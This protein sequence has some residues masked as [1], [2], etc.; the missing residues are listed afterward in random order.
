MNGLDDT[1]SMRRMIWILRMFEGTFSLDSARIQIQLFVAVLSVAKTAWHLIQTDDMFLAFE[2]LKGRQFPGKN[3]RLRTRYTWHISAILKGRQ[4]SWLPV[5]FPAQQVPSENGS[6]LK[7]KNLL[8]LG[9]NSFL[10]EKTP[11]Q[12]VDKTSLTFLSPLKMYPC[13]LKWM[14]KSEPQHKK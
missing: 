9:A 5:C 8:P 3:K 13:P 2:T 14:F 1:L 7:G 4:L 11:L 12:A 6:T 10:Y